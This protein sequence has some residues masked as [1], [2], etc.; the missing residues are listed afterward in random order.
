MVQPPS[1]PRGTGGD[2]LM[3]L[4]EN[5]RDLHGADVARPGAH[6]SERGRRCRAFGAAARAHVER[7]GA[8]TAGAVL[9]GAHDAFEALRR[10]IGARE[11]SP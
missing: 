11:R 3:H 6:V 10:S 8:C 9:A 4:R 5:A 1:D 7:S 2:V